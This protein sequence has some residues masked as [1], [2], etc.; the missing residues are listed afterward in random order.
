MKSWIKQLS[1]IAL[2]ALT[3]CDV[4][5]F[6]TEE[7][8]PKPDVPSIYVEPQ[9]CLNVTVPLELEDLPFY[10]EIFY[11]IENGQ[12]SELSRS[13]ADDG[14][15]MRF[16]IDVY[17][18]DTRGYNRGEGKPDF[19]IVHTTTDIKEHMD[20][21]LELGA[22]E[23]D[24]QIWADYVPLGTTDDYFYDV[25]NMNAVTVP[26]IYKA[27]DHYH[28]GNERYRDCFVGHASIDVPTEEEIL[29]NRADSIVVVEARADLERPQ[30]LFA[31]ETTDIRKF[32]EEKAK[33]LLNTEAFD[34]PS[35][36][37]QYTREVLNHY[38]VMITY[39]GYMPY[40]FNVGTNKPVDSAT[41]RC[42]FGK[43]NVLD[44][45]RAVM[46]FD[47]VFV[48]G[49]ESGVDIA[50]DVYDNKGVIVSTIG[51]LKVP[52]KRGKYTLVSGRFLSAD[53]SGGVGINPGFN[54]DHNIQIF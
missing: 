47:H 31:I 2:L 35:K 24:M 7:P 20:V 28:P 26:E 16:L 19:R 37:M 10:K 46:G 41:G 48:N 40:M 49:T 51:P 32:V 45:D 8:G 4:H 17:R 36:V 52:L 25:H 3:A 21:P 53:A 11:D 34:D 1:L 18:T 6:P 33:E 43:M 44:A 15:Q 54:G 9:L 22:G 13:A 29:A 27:G 30:A 23:Y 14:M 12:S 5:E 38:T 50:I 42:F 39:T